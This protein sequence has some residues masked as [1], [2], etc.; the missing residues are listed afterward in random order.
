MSDNEIK[1]RLH[2][3]I[4]NTSDIQVLEK[5]YNELSSDEND[6][7][8]DALTENQKQRLSESEEQY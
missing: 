3:L 8:W 2:E 7:W 1:N 5:I 4:E 6:D